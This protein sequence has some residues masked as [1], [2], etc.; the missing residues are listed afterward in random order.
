MGFYATKGKVNMSTLQ[1]ALKIRTKK[2][3]ILMMDA[4]RLARQSEDSCA[5]IL[6]IPVEEYRQYENGDRMASL[7]QLEVLAYYLDVP[8]EH[9]WGTEAKSEQ[10]QF[11]LNTSALIPLRQKVIGLT[12]RQVRQSAGLE[13]NDFARQ[14]ELEPETLR[15]YELGEEAIPLPLLEQILAYLNENISIVA[16][17]H[18]QIGR[19]YK[20]QRTVGSVSTYPDDI[21]EFLAKSVNEP[22]IDLARKLSE[23]DA[24]KLRA[25]A[26]SLLDITY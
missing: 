7:P 24:D 20:Q 23:F 21:K 22:Y 12:I 17:H 5:A 25:I 10:L 3:G 2:M 14:V 4:R 16:D 15:R 18:G 8:L 9:F 6:N 19:W 11:K 1:N 13:L 26:E